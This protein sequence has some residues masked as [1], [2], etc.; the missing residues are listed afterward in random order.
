MNHSDR[1]HLLRC[2]YLN[3]VSSVQGK[4]STYIKKHNEFHKIH[5]DTIKMHRSLALRWRSI[6]SFN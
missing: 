3:I 4:L 5:K 6:T 1:Y 2:Y